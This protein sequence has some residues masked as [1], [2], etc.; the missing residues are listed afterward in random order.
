M[1][2]FAVPNWAP[3]SC[4]SALSVVNLKSRTV[5]FASANGLDAAQR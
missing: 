3:K 1:E 4:L 2:T 5:K